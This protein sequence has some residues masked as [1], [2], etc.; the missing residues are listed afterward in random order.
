LAET[1]AV[2]DDFVGSLAESQ[3]FWRSAHVFLPDGVAAP[4]LLLQPAR[5]TSEE[6]A[7]TTKKERKLTRFMAALSSV[8]VQATALVAP[9]TVIGAGGRVEIGTRRE[10]VVGRPFALV[11]RA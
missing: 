4:E 5:A 1:A 2:Q 6:L 9:M 10:I 11:L 7:A 8:R 3:H